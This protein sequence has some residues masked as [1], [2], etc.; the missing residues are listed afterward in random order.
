MANRTA[1]PR[2]RARPPR[3]PTATVAETTTRSLG[4]WRRV[5]TATG[6][7]LATILVATVPMLV[8]YPFVQ[9][10]FAKGVMLGS[11]KG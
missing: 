5:A 11:R 4:Q 2:A 1:A 3:V 9:N 6:A 10:Y 8:V 7:M